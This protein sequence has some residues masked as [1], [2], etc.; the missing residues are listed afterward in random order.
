MESIVY[1]SEKVKAIAGDLGADLCGVA[2]MDRFDDAPAGFGP[3]DIYP[4]CRSVVVVAKRVPRG[5]LQ[6]KSCVPYTQFSRLTNQ[7]VDRLTGMLGLALEDLGMTAVPVPA[8]DPYEHWEPDRM[9]GRG[10]L[11]MRHAAHLAGL[12]VLG[13]N[14]LL[15]NARFGNMVQIGAVLVDA[16]IRPDPLTTE[17]NCP[18]HC[19]RCIEACP[20]K[21]LDGV[22]VDQRLCRASSAFVN[23]KGHSLYRCYACRK[24]CPDGGGTER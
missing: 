6:A 8:D 18:E 19:R 7:E 22:T 3:R 21:A 24:V 5:V 20:A 13:R 4:D 15:K 12:G 17:G 11:S 23:Q 10:I 9:Y 1:G 14:T 16:E 2:S